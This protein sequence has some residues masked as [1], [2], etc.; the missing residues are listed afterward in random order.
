MTKQILFLLLISSLF[1]SFSKKKHPEITGELKTWH[2][3]TL[4]ID[5]PGT[6]EF[7]KINPFLDYQLEVEFSNGDSR[8]TVPGFF[9]ADGNAAETSADEGNKWQVRFRP[10]KPG[11]W[12][13]TIHFK[14]GK[15]I[16][17]T[18]LEGTG[19]SVE[20]D[21]YSG[22]FTIAESDK[23]APDFRAKG[24]LLPKGHY[25]QFSDGSYFIKGG[26][27]SP[28]N[29][30]A[31]VDFDQ[32]YRYGEKAI[33]REGEANPKASIHKYEPHLKDWNEGDPSWQ[34]GKGKAMIGAINYLASE[35]MN[36]IYM[37]TMNIMGDGKD[38]WPYSDHNERYRFDCS[39]LDQWEIV[40]DYMQ[41]KGLMMHFVL[42]ETENECLL[43]GGR[44][45][46]QRKLYLREL[47]ARFGHHL[48]VTWNLGEEN[49]PTN[50]SPV[51]QDD[52]MRKAMANY[53]RKTNP[54][55]SFIV[56]HTHANDHHQDE[57]LNPMFGFEN[58]DGPS[59]QIGKVEKVHERILKFRKASADSLHPWVV[60][61]DEIGPAYKGVMPDIDDAAHDTIRH[62]ALWGSLMAGA[63]GVEWYFG[64]RYAHNDLQCEDWRSRDIWWDQTRY[65]INFFQDNLPY[66]EM[67]SADDLVTGNCYCFAKENEIYCIYKP[68]RVNS[69]S[70][71][72]SEQTKT[73]QVK[74]F[75]P[76]AGG[77][78]QT[79]TVHEVKASK[80][81]NIGLPPND[82]DKDW[83]AILKY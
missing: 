24:R 51:G 60:N 77:D 69:V 53:I 66:Y 44:T 40:F 43:D 6:S 15:N 48:A 14:K 45:D 36:S 67:N 32:T 34:G 83:V 25:L 2:K 49:G 71:D 82:T 57:Y 52:K 33:I 38:V 31:Y 39:K 22:E 3:V 26:A 64:Y 56:L 68:M 35:G 55:P 76:R 54:Y 81:T 23:N 61:L 18:E 59:M 79:G 37:L 21:N 16:A 78:L 47:I 8:Y 63:G 17:I 50:W 70:I 13:Y 80:N 1:F 28:E 41:Q 62:E 29:F 12:K 27:D 10:D 74:W 73:Y 5:G 20:F 30:L 11:N 4:T 42:Q 58:L 9:A 19:E 72:L 75:N 65:A 7:D 46:V